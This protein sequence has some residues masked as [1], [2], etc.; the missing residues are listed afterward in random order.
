MSHKLIQISSNRHQMVNRCILSSTARSSN[1]CTCVYF[2]TS[3]FQCVLPIMVAGGNLFHV[4]H[5]LMSKRVFLL[6]LS[7]R[8]PSFPLSLPPF[9][10]HLPK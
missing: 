9:H 2:S 3:T 10:F 8:F 7:F 4:I 5:Y 1:P 6:L